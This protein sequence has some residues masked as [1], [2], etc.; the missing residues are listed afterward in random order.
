MGFRCA[1]CH[2]SGL[3]GLASDGSEDPVLVRIAGSETSACHMPRKVPEG[4]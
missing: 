2:V 1:S 3:V 4:T